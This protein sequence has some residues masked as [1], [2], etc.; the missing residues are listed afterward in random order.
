MDLDFGYELDTL[1]FGLLFVVFIGVFIMFILINY[2][3]LLN[4]RTKQEIIDMENKIPECP[5][6][7]QCPNCDCPNCD[8][9]CPPPPKCP[10]NPKCPKNKECPKCPDLKVECPSVKEI[11]DG[12]F[13]GRSNA[14]LNESRFYDIEASN[15]YNGLSTSNFYEETYNFPMDRILNPSSPIRQ[16]NNDIDPQTV[17]NS[18]NNNSINTSISKSLNKLKGPLTN[19]PLS[20]KL[21]NGIQNDKKQNKENKE[22][23][24]NKN[25]K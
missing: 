2:I 1:T 21:E 7:P 6:C 8:I 23:K 3:I 24:E 17:N 19:N 4:D 10:E 9:S 15:S 18:Y 5:Q 20:R 22:N 25:D 14:I 12:V 16:F 11:V 13:P